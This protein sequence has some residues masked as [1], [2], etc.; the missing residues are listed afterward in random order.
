MNKYAKARLAVFLIAFV[1][2]MLFLYAPVWVV[3]P[4][5]HGVL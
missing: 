1:L 3:S 4:L 5:I 2:I